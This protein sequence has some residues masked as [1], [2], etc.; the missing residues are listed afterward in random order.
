MSVV[1]PRCH[2]CKRTLR[3]QLSGLDAE[4]CVVECERCSDVEKRARKT[5]RH[6]SLCHEPIVVVGV[7]GGV[8]LIC[9]DCAGK[10]EDLVTRE[11]LVQ[12]NRRLLDQGNDLR[13]KL[14]EMEAAKVAA[15]TNVAEQ[16]AKAVVQSEKKV[17]QVEEEKKSLQAELA[18]RADIDLADRL[19]TKMRERFERLGV[20]ERVVLEGFID[21]LGSNPEFVAKGWDSVPLA[22]YASAYLMRG[23]DE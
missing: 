19:K 5:L 16:I 12:A 13:E 21:W 17:A 18:Q 3:V 14:R 20:S 7:P 15:E 22:G 6:C 9:Q 2:T 11:K 8:R 4:I 10:Q 1:D 23:V